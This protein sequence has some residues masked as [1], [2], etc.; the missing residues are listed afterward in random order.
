MAAQD[1]RSSADERDAA[2]IDALTGARLRGPGLV[3]LERDIARHARTGEPL[4]LVFL[5]VD[6]LK[7][8]ND[9]GGHAAGDRLLRTVTDTI[10]AVLR[11]YDLIVRVGGDEFVC[12]LPGM[13]A[14]VATA[15][16]ATV[17]ADLKQGPARASVT[18]G[19]AALEPGD[20]VD[21]LVHRADTALYLH[22]AER[23]SSPKPAATR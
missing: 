4:T 12:A 18:V 1:R 7:V 2:T 17:N 22:R 3:E 8:V 16:M 14:D 6:G 10:R 13:T 23:S 15:R 9:C 20:T 19:V 5:D 21:A 11:P